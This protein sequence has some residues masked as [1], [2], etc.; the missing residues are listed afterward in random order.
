[1][2]KALV[3]VLEEG[4]IYCARCDEEM[5]LA[6]LPQYEFEEGI[7]LHSVQGYKCS[8]CNKVFFSVEQAQELEARTEELK[9][10]TFGF[11]RK[12]MISGRSL[13]VGIPVE[14]AEHVHLKAGT[15]VKILPV[16]NEGFL[17]K[18]L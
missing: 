3:K 8:S 7:T 6:V 14:L 15:A 16:S 1:M 9:E 13:V 11:K 17:V 18:K 10:C 5:K 4:K 12:V 2:V